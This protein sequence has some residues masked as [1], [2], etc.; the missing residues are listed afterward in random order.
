VL[1]CLLEDR[2]LARLKIP[3]LVER[4]EER[5]LEVIRFP[6]RDLSVVDDEA[7]LVELV[8][9]MRERSVAGKNVVVHCEGGLGRAGTIGGCY[10]ALLG[11]DGDEILD[12]LARSRSP[13]CPETPE[14]RQYVRDFA[15]LV[16]ARAR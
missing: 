8:L 13:R 3:D 14:Q 9:A 10:L 12:L 4:A 16:R 15:E 11:H 5:G 2:D 7:K 6:I 1:V